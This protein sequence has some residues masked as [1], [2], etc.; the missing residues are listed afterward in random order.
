[1]SILVM[2]GM[3]IIGLVLLIKG[4]D[5]FVDGASGLAGKN[6]GA[7]AGYRTYNCGFRNKCAGGGSKYLVRA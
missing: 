4:A 7:V 5:W 3:L 2:W 1:M 6:G